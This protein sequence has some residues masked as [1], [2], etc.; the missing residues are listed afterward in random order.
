MRAPTLGSNVEVLEKPKGALR[1]DRVWSVWSQ[2][3]DGWWIMRR[4]SGGVP[5]SGTTSPRDCSAPR[6]G[7]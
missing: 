6:S 7:R 1:D 2:S 3:P 5:S 4:P